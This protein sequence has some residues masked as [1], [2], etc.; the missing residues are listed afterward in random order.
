MVLDLLKILATLR[1]PQK[2]M[3]ISNEYILLSFP[4][5]EG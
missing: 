3:D 5:L 4:D 2:L 1:N